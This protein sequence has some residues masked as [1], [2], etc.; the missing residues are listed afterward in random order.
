MVDEL[1]TDM[2]A[3]V[4]AHEVGHG[5]LEKA[6]MKWT[7]FLDKLPPDFEP[8][9]IV[10]MGGKANHGD[11]H[12]INEFAGY[13]I[14]KTSKLPNKIEIE[15]IHLAAVEVLIKDNKNPTQEVLDLIDELMQPENTLQLIE[16]WAY[17]FT[18]EGI[19]QVLKALNLD[20]WVL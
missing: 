1:M 11:E 17:D 18:R 20:K 7:P 3:M 9:E 2:Y 13:V 6:L 5:I 4:F 12:L 10:M 8:P 19:M 15:P 14:R 16:E